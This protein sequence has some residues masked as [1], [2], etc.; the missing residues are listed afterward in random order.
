MALL[1]AR[2]ASDGDVSWSFWGCLIGTVWLIVIAVREK[3]NG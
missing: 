1:T 2:A 3:Q